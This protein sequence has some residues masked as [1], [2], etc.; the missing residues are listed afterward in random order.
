MNRRLAIRN[1]IAAS[2]GSLLERVLADQPEDYVLH[3]QVRLVLLDVSVKDS[4]G[5][6]VSGLSKENFQVFENDRPQR[7]K[8]FANNDE[9]VTIGILVDES[10]SMTPKRSQVLAAAE[11][12]IEAGNPLD[13]IFILHFNDRVMRGLPPHLLFSGDIQELRSALHRGV[14]EGKTALND[15]VVAGLEQLDLGRRDK[16]TLVVISDGGDNASNHNRHEML[17]LVERSVA[18]IYSIGLFEADDPDRDPGILRQL[19]KISGGEA[20]L[21]PDPSEMVPVLRRIAKDIRTRYTIGYAPPAGNGRVR[22]IQVRASAPG[23]G[24]LQIRTRASY[25][26]DEIESQK[27]R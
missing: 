4:K 1:L 7:V 14:P 26:Y 5:G 23:R 6:L 16:K 10:R 8:V 22:H 25:R 12:F 21:P 24:S 15:A 9:P 11:V 13:E 20:Y 17:D 18:T 19:A 2:A 3:S 27:T